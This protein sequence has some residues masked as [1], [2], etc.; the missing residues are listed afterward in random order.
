VALIGMT[1]RER[2]RVCYRTL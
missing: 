2:G 1:L